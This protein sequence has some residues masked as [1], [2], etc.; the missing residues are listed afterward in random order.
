MSEVKNAQWEERLPIIKMVVGIRDRW[1][2]HQQALEG[3]SGWVRAVAFSPD[4]K[5]LAS[6][7]EDR[8]VRLWDAATGEHQQT[9]EGHSGWVT[10]VAFSPDGK[11]LASASEDRTVR[12][13]D[14][15]TG[16]HQQTLEGHS[17]WVRAVAFSPD[18][19]TLASA[20]EDRTVRLWN[21]ATGEHQQ[22]LE[23]HS[24]WVWAVAFSPDGKT[25]AS[26]SE[27]RT[28]RLWNAV[29][30]EHQQTLE[31]HS[32]IYALSFSDDGTSLQTERGSLP[33]PPPLSGATA[34]NSPQPQS[35]I[36]V[37]D[38]WVS[39]HTERILWLP[40]EY[41][42]YSVAVHRGTVAFGYTSGR[43]AIIE[44]ALASP[45]Q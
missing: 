43:V 17:G 34:M 39:R 28:V 42:P 18:G 45:S 29:T 1:G 32:G 25:L 5:T 10:A 2:V 31:G 22:T 4:G 11:T 38:Q 19:K 27:D 13:W 26:A 36:F 24:Y 6:A 23:G 44:F 37:K 41:R 40:P 12:L 16:E 3:H 33:I 15:A 20:S 8:T 21:A 35:S 14:A 7:S 30:G 9:L